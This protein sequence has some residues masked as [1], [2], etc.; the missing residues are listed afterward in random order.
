VKAETLLVGT[1]R[2]GERGVS[3]HGPL[4]RE[5]L[6]R[7]DRYKLLT[8]LVI[9]RP[10]AWI[11]TWS[12]EGI[13]NCAPF[14]LFNLVSEDPPLCAIGINA[15]SDGLLKDTLRN[16]RRTREL[17]LNLVDEA[18][19]APMRITGHEFAHDV[20]EFELAGLTTVPAT[21]VAHPRISQAAASLECVVDPL[22]S[23]NAAQE[24]VIGE[25][26]HLHT[27]DGIIDPATLRIAEGLYQPIGRLY[28]NRYCTTRD[29][30]DLPAELLPNLTTAK[31]PLAK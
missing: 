29:H 11:S 28:G 20:S 7:S 3:R 24:I 21:R 14:S 5:H 26:I 10:I 16:I 13:A 2:L 15:R 6:R 30:F 31:S 9:P 8:G 12:E 23:I 22:V 18:M 17:V 1:Q 25:I 27:R 19:A 4:H